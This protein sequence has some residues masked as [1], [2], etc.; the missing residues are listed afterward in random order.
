MPGISPVVGRTEA[1]AK[2]KLRYLN[3]MIDPELAVATLQNFM[4]DVDLRKYPLDEP[5]PDIPQ[6]E[7]NQSRQTLA[8]EMARR[9]N[10]TLRQL[11]SWFAGT[12]GHWMPIGTAEHI[13]DQM[14]ECFDRYGA[15]GFNV[16]PITLPGELKDFTSLVV[17][18]MQ[19]RG[20]F[21]V[22]YEGPTLRDHLGLARPSFRPH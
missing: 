16:M 15:D 10:M 19:R 22:D 6:T 1:E 7:G 20:R 11:A 12:R 9:E 4:V 5:L 13:V 18:E 21:R 2:E 17:P 8:L 3:S 14:E